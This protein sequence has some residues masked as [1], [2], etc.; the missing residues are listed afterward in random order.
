VLL[1]LD[2][3]VFLDES[4][5]TGPQRSVWNTARWDRLERD[6]LLSSRVYIPQV[7]AP[8]LSFMMVHGHIL[9]ADEPS[10]IRDH[11]PPR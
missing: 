6:R 8:P 5:F 7:P 3:N 10:A 4:N 1:V 9:H 11:C 2:T